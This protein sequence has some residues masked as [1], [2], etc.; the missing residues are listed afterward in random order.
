MLWEAA[1]SSAF[2][3]RFQRQRDLEQRLL[4]DHRHRQERVVHLPADRPL[5][6]VDATLRGPSGATSILEFDFS[7]LTHRQPL[8]CGNVNRA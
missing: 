1:Y 8:R 2:Q 5:Q 7:C 3:I 4:D 6:P